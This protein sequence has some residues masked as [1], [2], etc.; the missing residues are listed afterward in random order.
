[1]RGFSRIENPLPENSL[2]D[3]PRG[4]EF[5]PLHYVSGKR[6][7]EPWPEGMELAVFG[8]G[9]FWGAERLFWQLPGVCSTAVGYAGGITANPD[10]KDVCGGRTGH[11]EVVIVCFDPARISYQE[12]LAC[13]WENHDPTQG[14][15][16]G[17]DRGSQYRSAIYT[18]ASRQQ[19]SAQASMT[20]CQA[21]L[22][23]LGY[24]EITTEIK[25]LQALLLC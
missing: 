19:A 5:S 11:A 23:D 3:R 14:M 7:C 24:S 2:P 12:L 8:M 6:I 25:P 21:L 22:R 20:H 1:M 4:P 10:Y 9:C 13:F 18:L 15:R 16:Q 17:N